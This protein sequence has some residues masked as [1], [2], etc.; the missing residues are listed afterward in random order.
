[1]GRGRISA[2]GGP[3]Q[4]NPARL[5]RFS[6]DLG[7]AQNDALFRKKRFQNAVGGDNAVIQYVL[8]KMR[9][10]NVVREVGYMAARMLPDVFQTGGTHA[11]GDGVVHRIAVG[12]RFDPDGIGRDD[13]HAVARNFRP[14]GRGERER[15]KGEH[16]AVGIPLPDEPLIDVDEADDARQIGKEGDGGRLL[17]K[18]FK[19]PPERGDGVAQLFVIVFD[20][21]G[22]DF[23]TMHAGAVFELRIT[24]VRGGKIRAGEGPARLEKHVPDALEFAVV[25]AE[26]SGASLG[27]QRD[28]AL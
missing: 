26:N 5:A 11:F 14:E 1:M 23:G 10:E 6:R 28:F 15:G 25:S 13:T 9:S 2:F 18:L 16:D 12:Q 21:G 24:R 7:F 22:G 3:D 27:D 20:S 19:R 8:R 17:R 4:E